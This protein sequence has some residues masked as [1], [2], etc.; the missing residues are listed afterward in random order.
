M[1]AANFSVTS[2]GGA[3]HSHH[4]KIH[5]PN[6]IILFMA[7]VDTAS[8]DWRHALHRLIG[9]L[10]W[11]TAGEKCKYCHPE[12]H[13][14]ESMMLCVKIQSMTKEWNISNIGKSF[15][16]LCDQSGIQQQTKSADFWLFLISNHE[17]V[18]VC[19]CSACSVTYG[20]SMTRAT[21][22]LSSL[23][24]IENHCEVYSSAS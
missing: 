15:F 22:S 8:C 23:M 4:S 16:F 5:H 13:L 17:T 14:T 20:I 21:P 24:V 12:I 19:V 18:K 1:R 3:P 6:S 2:E 11:K 10:N 7:I 9:M